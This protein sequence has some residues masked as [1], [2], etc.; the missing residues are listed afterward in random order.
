LFNLKDAETPADDT[1]SEEDLQP[2]KVQKRKKSIK[3]SRVSK[4][5]ATSAGSSS[6]DDAT[7]SNND[8]S[9]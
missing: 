6:L 2:I 4:K 3:L 9:E 7:D 8:Y 1:S 5:K